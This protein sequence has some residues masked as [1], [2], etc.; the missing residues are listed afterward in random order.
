MTEVHDPSGYGFPKWERATLQ[1]MKLVLTIAA[2]LGLGLIATG[3][4]L[5]Y[6]LQERDNLAE[7]ITQLQSDRR[8]LQS[9]IQIGDRQYESCE[10]ELYAHR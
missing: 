7:Q 8:D 6:A 1:R 3:C 9:R 10:K 4:K 5:A 2:F